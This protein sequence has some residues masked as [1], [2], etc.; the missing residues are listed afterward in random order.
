MRFYKP[1]L[2]EYVSTQVDMPWE[3]LQGVA[4]QKQ[5]G[6]DSALATGD[7]ANK[8]LN[9]EVNPGDMEGKQA[10]Q[11]EYN[12]QLYKITD[13]IRQ[14]GDFNTASREFA[15]I[16]RD[17]A[18]DKRIQ[19]MTNAVEPYKR[20][21]PELEGM[22]A[23][24]ELQNPW[25]SDWDPNYSTYNPKTGE[26][27]PYTQTIGVKTPNFFQDRKE[28]F[29]DLK[30]SESGNGYDVI[31][32]LQYLADGTPN[33]NYGS[34]TSVTT[35]G[36]AISDAMIMQRAK[37]AL[38]N[39]KKTRSYQN[40]L[41]KYNWLFANGQITDPK[42]LEEYSKDPNSTIT[43]LADDYSINELYVHGRDQLQSKYNQEVR[44]GFMGE[45][46]VK[47]TRPL[48]EN[49]T[50]VGPDSS[51][52]SQDYNPLTLNDVSYYEEKWVDTPAGG[53]TNEVARTPTKFSE[54]PEK[55]RQEFKSLY[56]NL[57]GEAEY[58][59]VMTGKKSLTEDDLSKVVQLHN[60]LHLGLRTNTSTAQIGDSEEDK[61]KVHANLFGTASGSVNVGIMT[62]GLGYSENTKVYDAKNNEWTTLGEIEAGGKNDPTEYFVNKRY[63][64]QNP[65]YKLSG[66]DKRFSKGYSIVSKD[67]QHQ[68]IIPDKEN[69]VS[70]ADIVQAQIG[71][72]IYGVPSPLTAVKDNLYSIYGKD[73]EGNDVFFLAEK[74]AQGNMDYYHSGD[75]NKPNT[76]R[77][78]TDLQ[79]WIYSQSSK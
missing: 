55:Y 25:D 43:K 46:W 16:I 8:L 71:S 77:T 17:I 18:Q 12:N 53:T 49:L 3:F 37:E 59:K 56:K 32:N 36:G 76:Y 70:Q 14:T 34:K 22:I 51:L 74:D 19:I 73:D 40:H 31:D 69:N 15:N 38:F 26:L 65:L 64:T 44:Q 33:P 67:G 35:S 57:Y 5:K 66:N 13:Y 78:A 27:R 29:G 72:A 63:T 58:V 28:S 52:I 1:R 60:N 39:H 23:K 21:K 62:K 47:Q 50:T 4:E 68:Y 48:E 20:Q 61:K 54:V 10:V 9:F 79:R 42:L 7:A 41:R 24:G 30:L 2:R 45:G 11:K 75:P 6:Y